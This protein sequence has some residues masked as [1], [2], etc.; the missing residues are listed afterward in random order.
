MAGPV[1]GSSAKEEM[2]QSLCSGD[3]RSNKEVD[4]GT[5]GF[6]T[7]ATVDVQTSVG[8]VCARQ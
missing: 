5:G 7:R 8:A 1:L 6:I 4:T 3:S 2:R